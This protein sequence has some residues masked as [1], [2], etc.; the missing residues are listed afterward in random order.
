[1]NTFYAAGRGEHHTR[2]RRDEVGAE[3]PEGQAWWGSRRGVTDAGS[4][5]R[6]VCHTR[7]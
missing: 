5:I 1:M 6:Y 3:T 4:T 7:A 2:R